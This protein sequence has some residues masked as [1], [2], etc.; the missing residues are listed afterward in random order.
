MLAKTRSLAVLHTCSLSC[1]A[2]AALQ[3]LVFSYP[4]LFENVLRGETGREKKFLWVIKYFK[5]KSSVLK[6]LTETPFLKTVARLEKQ[7]S[8]GLL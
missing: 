5:F 4:N 6:V 3:T 2:A 1:S 8:L 7:Q